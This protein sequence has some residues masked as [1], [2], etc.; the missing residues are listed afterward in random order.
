MRPTA[1][2]ARRRCMNHARRTTVVEAVTVECG[3]TRGGIGVFFDEFKVRALFCGLFRL[4]GRCN[5]RP[6]DREKAVP[7]GC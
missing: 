3:T 2:A 4:L 1:A 6:D 7:W 5:P